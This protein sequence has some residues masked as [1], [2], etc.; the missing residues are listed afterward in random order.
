[1]TQQSSQAE[2]VLEYDAQQNAERIEA[3]QKRIDAARA[4]NDTQQLAVELYGMQHLM[5]IRESLNG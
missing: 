5:A 1:M 4:A 3:C 2:A